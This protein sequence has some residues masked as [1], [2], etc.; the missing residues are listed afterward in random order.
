MA[1]VVAI[2]TITAVAAAQ[3]LPAADLVETHWLAAIKPM[4]VLEGLIQQFYNSNKFFM[5]GGGGREMII[6]A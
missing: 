3:T 4:A 1:V 2:N 6:T 5:G